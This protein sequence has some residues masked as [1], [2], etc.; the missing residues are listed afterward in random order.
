M[1]KFMARYFA[2]ITLRSSAAVRSAP[3]PLE[4]CVLRPLPIRVPPPLSIPTCTLM[5]LANLSPTNANQR[6]TQSM[7]CAAQDFGA[8]V[9][10]RKRSTLFC[11]KILD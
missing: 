3:L 2:Q 7:V 1:S 8:R 6:R 9:R 5:Y 10:M 11:C 4:Y